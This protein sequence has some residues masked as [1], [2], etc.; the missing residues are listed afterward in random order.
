MLA[1]RP[2]DKETTS[3]TMS[4]VKSKDTR[5]E[6]TVCRALW[7]AGL[8]YRKHLKSVPGTP[9]IAFPRIKVAV[10]C[11]SSFWHGH[12]WVNEQKRFKANREYWIPKIERNMRRD[13][14]VNEELGKRGWVVLRF[15]DFEIR[16][17][18][19]GIVARVHSAIASRKAGSVRFPPSRNCRRP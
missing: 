18:I 2:R 5:L 6:V 13:Q 11:D 10:F 9:D 3:F 17:S 8:R 4:R 1:Y 12:D 14:Q 16:D 7:A 19:E 15:W